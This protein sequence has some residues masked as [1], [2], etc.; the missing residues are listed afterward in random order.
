MRIISKKKGIIALLSTVLFLSGC[1]VQTQQQIGQIIGQAAAGGLNTVPSSLEIANGLKQ[2]LEFGA[3]SGTQRLSAKDGF[4]GNAAIKILFP[5]EAQKVESTLRSVGLGSLADQVIL[6]LNRAAED[7][8]KEAKPI[9]VDAIKQMSI[10][11]AMQILLGGNDSATQYFKKTTTASLMQKFT[12]VIS[13]SLNKV[14]ATRYWGDAATAYNKLP[15]VKPINTNLNQYVAQKAVEA[16]FLQ[17]S[18]E[19]LRIRNTISA[20][21]TG[22]LQ[23]VFSYADSKK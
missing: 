5:S 4:L 8:A 18:Q 9:F 20:R 15:L 12:P 16:L 11:D 1:D 17:V 14:G 13:N 22:L 10:A 19:E 21:S 23:K 3:I 2:A 6:S 7:A